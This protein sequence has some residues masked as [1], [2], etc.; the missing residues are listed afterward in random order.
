[1]IVPKKRELPVL[2]RLAWN[3]KHFTKAA[4]KRCAIA[5]RL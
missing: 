1:M 4:S 5:K 3:D 2:Y